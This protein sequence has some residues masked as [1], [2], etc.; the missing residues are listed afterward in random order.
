MTLP[1]VSKPKRRPRGKPWP[2]G[3]SGNPG[4]RPKSEKP[5]VLEADVRALARASG[6]KSI[7]LLE[8][9]RDDPEAPPAVRCLAANS[10]LDRGYGRPPQS[11]DVTATMT[12]TVIRGTARDV[13]RSRLDRLAARMDEIKGSGLPH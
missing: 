8:M 5:P 12:E 3:V 11:V 7:A 6:E 1:I 10:L 4:G 2:K 9:I 13:L